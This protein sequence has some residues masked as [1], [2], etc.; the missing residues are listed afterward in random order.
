MSRAD[1]GRQKVYDAEDATDL[2]HGARSEDFTLAEAQQIVNQVLADKWVQQHWDASRFRSGIEVIPGRT[3][4]YAGIRNGRR[5]ICLGPWARQEYIV[6]HE[7]AHHLRGLSSGHDTRFCG[8]LLLL[9]AR[10]IGKPQAE[11][12]RRS[13]GEHGVSCSWYGMPN[14]PRTVKLRYGPRPTRAAAKQ[15]RRRDA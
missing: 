10:F 1:Y 8:T 2:Y 9:V 6:L 11:T 13:F 5:V 3:R 4:G 7:L 12:L 14:L 15:Q